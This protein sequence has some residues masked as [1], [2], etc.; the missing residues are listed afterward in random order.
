MLDEITGYPANELLNTGTER[1]LDYFEEKYRAE[2]PELNE[3]GA[4]FDQQE[5]QIDVRHDGMRAVTDRS[6]PAL[7]AGTR[8]EF[9]VPFTGDAV[10]FNMRASTSSINPPHAVVK[11]GHVLFTYERTDHNVE[12]LKAGYER[13]L[14]AVKTGLGWVRKDAEGFNAALRGEAQQVIEARRARVL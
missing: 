9:A 3:P 14:A 5:T 12:A 8:Y 11:D 2:I 7:V 10:L 4:V 13:D 1:L 6:R